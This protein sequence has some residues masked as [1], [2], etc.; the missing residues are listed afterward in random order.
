MGFKPATNYERKLRLAIMGAPK[1]GKT[2]TALSLAFRL[3]EGGKVGV[4]DTENA[5]ASKYQG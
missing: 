1:T 5:S 4:I 3:A 2:Y